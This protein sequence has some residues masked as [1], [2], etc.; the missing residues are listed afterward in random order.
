MPK[1]VRRTKKIIYAFIHHQGSILVLPLLYKIL[2][3]IIGRYFSIFNALNTGNYC[4]MGEILP[5]LTASINW[6]I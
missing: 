2:A 6:L 1:I 3:L 4:P 5:M